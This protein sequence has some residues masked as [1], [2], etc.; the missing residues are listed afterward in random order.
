MTQSHDNLFV[1]IT[2]E[3]L[4]AP[5]LKRHQWAALCEEV[6]QGCSL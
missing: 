3:A 2:P 4:A 5:S 1:S 6:R